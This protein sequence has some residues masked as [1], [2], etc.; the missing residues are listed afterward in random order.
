MC[1]EWGDFVALI[2]PQLDLFHMHNLTTSTSTTTVVPFGT[3]GGC[4]TELDGIWNK[5]N[6]DCTSGTI[7]WCEHIGIEN[8][9][10]YYKVA[11]R[12]KFLHLKIKQRDFY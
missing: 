7:F 4:A 5:V 1:I 11:K 3:I 12:A 10:F 8:Y 2:I 9:D 6:S